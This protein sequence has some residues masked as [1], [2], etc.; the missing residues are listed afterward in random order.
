[1]QQIHDDAQRQSLH[2]DN[3]L[4]QLQ[5]EHQQL[6]D[7]LKV[8]ADEALFY[9]QHHEHATLQLQNAQQPNLQIAQLQSKSDEMVTH[10]EKCRLHIETLEQKLRQSEATT[11]TSGRPCA[12]WTEQMNANH[13]RCANKMPTRTSTP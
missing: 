11:S 2:K 6:A 3:Q 12:N 5:A 1:M 8:K 7:E 9:K 13:A 4:V 10:A